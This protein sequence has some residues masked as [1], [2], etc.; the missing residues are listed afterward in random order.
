MSSG[1]ERSEGR[2]LGGGNLLADTESDVH[3]DRQEHHSTVRRHTVIRV[4]ARDSN[5]VKRQT[6]I[7]S[8]FY[9]K[10]Y[11]QMNK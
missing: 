1:W 11:K 5:V 3:F 10:D 2:L 4:W 7:N 8:I 6:K 9:R